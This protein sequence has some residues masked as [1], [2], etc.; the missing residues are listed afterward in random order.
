MTRCRQSSNAFRSMSVALIALWMLTA[1][2]TLTPLEARP[3]PMPDGWLMAEPS[4]VDPIPLEPLKIEP[5]RQWY[6]ADLERLWLE[7]AKLK[8]LQDHGRVVCNWAELP[9]PKSGLGTQA[10]T[11][12]L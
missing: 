7:V 6:L 12:P 1:C 5:L 10:A 11:A 8:A 9:S 3:C 2:E 4:R